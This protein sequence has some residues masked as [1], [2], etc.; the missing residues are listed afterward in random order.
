MI[1]TTGQAILQSAATG[2]QFAVEASELQ[3]QIGDRGAKRL[4]SEV[5]HVARIERALG[6]GSVVSCEWTVAE[7]P[8]GTLC[9]V[10]HHTV[11]C[12]LIQNFTL[13]WQRPS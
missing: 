4:G 9:H 12:L 1:K 2:E 10:A 5:H 13:L 7:F 6:N 8:P 3:W 11:S